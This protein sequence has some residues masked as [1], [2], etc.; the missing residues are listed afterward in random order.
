MIID[1]IRLMKTNPHHP[2]AGGEFIEKNRTTMTIEIVGEDKN[3][4]E[5]TCSESTEYETTH[6]EEKPLIEVLR[7]LLSKL[8][9][10]KHLQNLNPKPKQ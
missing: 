10:P 9:P 1:R 2:V 6:D 5:F 7:A 3:G 4:Q 8:S